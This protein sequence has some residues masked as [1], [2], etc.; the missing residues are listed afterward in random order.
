MKAGAESNGKLPH[1]FVHSKTATSAPEFVVEDLSLGRT[2]DDDDDE[3]E[4][5]G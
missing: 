5:E 3:S 1:P 2:L 4:G